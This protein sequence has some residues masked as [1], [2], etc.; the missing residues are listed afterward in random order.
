MR[1]LL[2]G[3][4]GRE[5]ALAWRLSQSPT[6]TKLFACPGN[7][8][9]GLLAELLPDTDNRGIA[10]YCREKGIDMVL[11]GPEAPLVAGL[12]DLLIAEGFPV[13][14]PTEAAA[15]LEG[16]KAYAKDLMHNAHI[17]TAAYETFTDPQEANDFAATLYAEGKKVVV[18][19]SGEA[20]GK[21]VVVTDTFAEAKEAINQMLVQ[22]SHG[23][24]GETIV[25]EERLEGEEISLLSLRS[26]R[27]AFVCPLIRD[28]KRAGDGDSGSNTGGMGAQTLIGEYTSA[29]I[30]G[31]YQMFCDHA[32]ELL[33]SPF[34]GTLFAGLM[35]TPEGPK[36]LE[37]NCRFGDPETQV[38]TRLGEFDWGQLL[39][40]LATDTE[41]PPPAWRDDLHCVAITLASAG[42]PGAYAKDMPIS[43]LEHAAMVEGVIVF[44][45]GT[46]NDAGRLV[47]AGGRVLTVTATGSSLDE[48]C[49]KAYEAVRLISFEGMQYRTDIAQ[50]GGPRSVVAAEG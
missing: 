15:Q 43:G 12:A 6:V 4:G 3:G 9:I 44:Q 49:R 50:N 29:Q 24:A 30:Q 7:P 35:V 47:T 28:Y 42:Y 25:V 33:E 23:A 45:A 16:S 21:G 20:L 36:C 18:K 27:Q 22:H 1:V 10:G 17:P 11:V 19:A 31:W 5:H 34:V 13:Y 37:Y 38:L 48:A 26:Q 14:G 41:T 40:N 8:G 39:Y 2:I 46:R 32:A